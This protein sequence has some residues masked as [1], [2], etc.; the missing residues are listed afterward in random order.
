MNSN[1]W[2]EYLVDWSTEAIDLL[3]NI[4]MDNS[5]EEKELIKKGYL[6]NKGVSEVEIFKAELLLNK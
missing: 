5:D 1:E 3:K 4:N 2:K 6:G